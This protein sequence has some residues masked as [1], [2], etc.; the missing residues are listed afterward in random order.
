MKLIKGLKFGRS[1]AI[2]W[3]KV[4]LGDVY[5]GTESLGWTLTNFSVSDLD[6][7]YTSTSKSM[8][9]LPSSYIPFA[10]IT[11]P[12]SS[13]TAVGVQTQNN[14]ASVYASMKAQLDM[15]AKAIQDYIANNSN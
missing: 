9:G 2:D 8:T 11:I 15:I 4:H 1:Y 5:V 12:H 13:V 14:L 7:T 6:L 3:N 10:S